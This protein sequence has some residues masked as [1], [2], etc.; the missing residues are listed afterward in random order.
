MPSAVRIIV[1]ARAVNRLGAFTLPFLAVVLVDEFGASLAEAGMVLALFGV[2]TIPSR[3]VGGQLA[4]RFGR[5]RTIVVGLVGCAIAQTWIVVAP[6][7]WSAIAAVSLLG[8]VFEIYEPPSQAVVA[9]AAEPAHRPAAYALLGAAMAAAAVVAGVLASLVVQWDLRWLFAIDAATCL[10][11]AV[12]VAVALPP[13]IPTPE[14][15]SQAQPAAADGL[16]AWRD[17]RLVLMLATGTAFAILY[18]QLVTTLPLTLVERGLPRSAI[19]IVL[20]VSAMTVIAGQRL[21]RARGLGRLDPFRAMAFGYLL[22]AVGLLANGLASSLPAFVSATVLWSLGD[23]ILLGHAQ[24]VVATLAADTT[25]GR[26]LA[27]YGTSWGIAGA[28]A[29]FAGTQ[30]LTTLGPAGLWTACAVIALS[31]AAIQPVLRRRLQGCA[32]GTAGAK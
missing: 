23:I 19:G 18:L 21:L 12:L 3:L 20:A 1:V 4:D 32:A 2:A 9:D 24:A 8:L 29:P 17:P 30:L 14:S 7:L 15:A 11:C 22:L 5:K 28:I 13:S 27:A 26:Y 25:R 6:G 10:A 16:S 31:L